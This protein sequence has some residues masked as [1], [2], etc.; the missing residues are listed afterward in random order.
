MN[1]DVF[2]NIITSYSD[3]LIK[4]CYSVLGNYHD[5]EDAAQDTFVRLYY[6]LEDI[7]NEEAVIAYMYRMAYTISIDLLRK[8]KRNKDI[9]DK[10]ERFIQDN[11]DSYEIDDVGEGYISEELY[12]AIMK[13]KPE[14]RALVHAIAVDELSYSE[15]A[16]IQGKSEATLRKRYERAKK[17]LIRE[18][19]DREN[20]I[21][22]D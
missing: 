6:K 22:A 10:Y 7:K 20:D 3:R 4:Y 17:K 21:W 15:I 16:L 13:L 9:S 8:R 2:N 12:L 5:A 19:E 11:P 14:D 18:L 1:E